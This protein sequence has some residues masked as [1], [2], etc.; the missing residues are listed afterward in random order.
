[1]AVPFVLAAWALVAAPAAA[2]TSLQVPLQFDFLN[3]GAKSLAMGG[4]FTGVADDATATLANPAGLAQLNLREVSVEGRFTSTSTPF[5]AGGRLSGTPF[6]EGIDTVG[7][8]VFGTSRDR[9]AGPT[10]ISVVLPF[11]GN[12]WVVAG[13]RHE[14]VRVDQEFFSTG[15]FQ[16]DP[17]ELTSRR[18]TPQRGERAVSVTTYG[19]A[20][21]YVPRPD[22]AI[23]V[24]LA[25]HRFSIDSVFT[26]Y[27]TEGFLG[28][29][30]LSR[31]IG[32]SSQQGDDVGLSPSVGVFVGAARRTRAGLLYRHGPSFEFRTV[33]G[34]APERTVTFRVPHTLALG[35]SHRPRPTVILAAEVTAVRYA[36]LEQEF[37]TDQARGVGRADDFHVANGVEA[38]V[39][40]QYLAL[41]WRW[42]P[43]FRLGAWYDPNHSVTFEPTGT[44][45]DA[46]QRTFDERLGVALSKGRRRVHATGGL[47]LSFSPRVE[48]NV[49]VDVASGRYV[50]STSII[51]RES[52]R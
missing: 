16:Q 30:N 25:A 9:R 46:D 7:G 42:A 33:D 8:P 22:V 28:A 50:V 34:L 41:A 39:G 35:V 32:R 24:G 13:Y 48:W 26:R 29:P 40:G 51:L 43:K 5:L 47:G 15:V 14:L 3:P 1:M 21:A 52:N 4:A 12:R 36:R 45:P 17:S 31:E 38:H 23:G 18:D 11:R 44:P 37:V 19:G 6:N 20:L 2:Q 27:D 49:G 10:F